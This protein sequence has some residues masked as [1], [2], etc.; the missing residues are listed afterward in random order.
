MG[1]NGINIVTTKPDLLERAL[2]LHLKR[3][4]KDKRRPILGT[5]TKAI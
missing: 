5:N 3:I 2:I 4:S 1:I